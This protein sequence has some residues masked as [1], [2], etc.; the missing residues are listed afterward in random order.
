MDDEQEATAEAQRQLSRSTGEATTL[1]QRL[2]GMEAGVRPEELE[3][4][5]RKM[6][7]RLQESESQLE[8]A[9]SKAVS[10]EKVKNRLQM[11][12]EAITSDL[13]LVRNIHCGLFHFG[14]SSFCNNK[15]ILC[16]H[17]WR[18]YLLLFMYRIYRK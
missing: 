5:K 14:L 12:M 9:L 3:D 16:R 1:R 10:I 11:E 8:A 7:A 6:S 18:I 2:E 17:G 15:P 4:I 13:E